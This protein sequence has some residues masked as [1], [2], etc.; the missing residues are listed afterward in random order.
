MKIN[1]LDTKKGFAKIYVNSL[2]D[3][4]HLSKVIEEGDIVRARSERKVKLGGESEKQRVVRKPITIKIRVQRVSL[5]E[6][7]LRVRG[8]MIAGPE[9]IPLHSSHTI[10]LHSGIEFELEKAEWRKFHVERLK[11]AEKESVA[12]KVLIC[13]LDDEEANL[14]HLT[15]SGIKAIAHLNLRLTKKR[16][17]EKRGNDIEKVANEVIDKSK[18]IDRIVLAS[19]LFWKETV[20]KEI[21]NKSDD[22]AKKVLMADVSTGSKKGF[23]EILSRGVVDKIIKD[24]QLAKE[25]KLINQVLEQISKNMD[26][27]A[28]GV[29]ETLKAAEAAAL[30]FVIVS[31]KLMSRDNEN[32]EIVKKIIE[33][34]EVNKGEVHIFE[35]DSEAG[36]QLLGLGGIG[37]ILRYKVN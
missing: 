27:V 20:L 26:L 7:S 30:K 22:V 24:S 12:P 11:T 37:G 16:L 18:N 4:W 32:F 35:S 29:G 17:E 15:P 21:K 2:D 5:N 33:L 6:S 1:R 34:V 19:P 36:K 28:Y 31:D 23:T 9:D 3:L 8:E 10:D 25:E 13:I 14:A